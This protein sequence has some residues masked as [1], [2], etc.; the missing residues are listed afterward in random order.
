MLG[1][2][3][4]A[5]ADILA[6]WHKFNDGYGL[7][8]TSA[9]TKLADVYLS[10][11]TATIYGGGGSRDTWGSTDGTFGAS[12]AVG[13]SATDGAM[14]HRTDKLDI[15]MT[16]VNNTGSN[17]VLD[18]LVFD[19]ASVSTNA[20]KDLALYYDSGNL[21]V[22]AGTLVNSTTGTNANGLTFVSDYQDFDWSLTGL[23]DRTLAT[24]ET[25]VF[26]FTVSN[27]SNSTQALALDNIAILGTGTPGGPLTTAMTA[28][29]NHITGTSTLTNTQINSQASVIATY[30]DQIGDTDAYITQALDLVSTY[31]TIKGAL[32]LNSTTSATAGFSR[33]DTS[34][35]DKALAVAMLG[36]Y[37][38]LIDDA[39][40]SSNLA[41]RRSLLEG[42]AFASASYFPGAVT[43]PANPNAVYSVQIN[44]SQP[45]AWG[46]E[47]DFQTQPAR[48]PTGAYLAPGS[49]AT[50]TVPPA[51]VNKGFQVRVGAHVADLKNKGSVKRF[52]RTTL[53][54]NITSTDTLVANPLGGGIYIEVPYLAAEGLVTVDIKNTV[55]SPFYSNTVARQTTL[56]Q[57]QT[58]ERNHPGPWA[59]FESDKFMMNVPRGWI[60]NYADPV[61]TMANW[62]LA[63]DAVSDL[64]GLPRVRPKTV[65]YCQIDVLI[66]A[67]AFSPGY[68]QSNDTYS[69]R[70]AV[71]GNQNH[72]LLNGPKFC[73]H[74]LFHELGHAAA[75]TKFNGELE[76]VV[77]LLYVPVHNRMFGVSLDEAFG[78]SLNTNAGAAMTR[79]H[80]ALNWV[81]TEKFRNGQ[82][83]AATEMNYQHRGYGKYVEIAGLFGWEALGNFW[84]SVAVDYE[85]GITYSKNS[86]PPDSRIL[87][88]S[89]AAGVDLT[90]L[91]H[92]WGVHPNNASSLKA[93]IQAAQL[94]KSAK[95]YDRLVYY[96]TQVPMS[97]SEFA[98]HDSAIHNLI[99]VNERDWYTSMR[100]GWTQALGLASVAKIQEIID[101]Y[102]P[103]GRPADGLVERI[104]YSES[105]ENGM[106]QWV[107]VLTDDY[108]WTRY[109][110]YTPTADSGPSAASDGTFYLYAEGH[111]TGSNKTTSIECSF[112]LTQVDTATLTFDYHMFGPYIDY[113]SLDVFNGTTWVT[114]VWKKSG[115]QQATS[116][117]PWLTASVSLAPYARNTIK[118]RFNAKNSQWNA[119][120]SAI[121][122]IRITIPPQQLPYAESFETG[123]GS[124]TQS[125]ADDFD[126]TRHSGYTETAN[127]GPSGAS[128]GTY[129]IYLEGHD[130]GVQYKSALME[131][132]FDFSGMST[133]SMTFDYHIYGQYIDYLAL[134]VFAGSTWTLDV[135]KRTN[136]QQAS[137]EDPW[138][139]ASVNL[140]PYAGNSNVTL[141]FRSKNKQWHAADT[142]L[143]NLRVFGTPVS[144]YAT[145]SAGH[146]LAGGFDADDDR[147]GIANGM[148]FV[149][150]G[151]PMVPNTSI[152]P[153]A[154]TDATHL[155]FSYTR[156][157]D[158]KTSTAQTVQW[159]TDLATWT[160][161]T[162]DPGGPDSVTINIPLTHEVN[163]KLYARLKV[164]K[165]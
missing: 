143:D 157:A 14:G 63:M 85:N 2:A 13:T 18:S 33:T 113:L 110:G 137:S 133:V 6:G 94:P 118:L 163:G 66:D 156:T 57:W 151:N 36:V 56:A 20:P 119:S 19:L 29:K 149:L 76:S 102:F 72:D 148:E 103:N 141:R 16:L 78:R 15:F 158:S 116:E 71:N 100:T 145:W 77:N 35:V 109:S 81:V 122:N 44:A 67:S 120:D 8:Q 4:P 32:F 144:P 38:A 11:L 147:D 39:F 9:S 23:A 65:L 117:D 45:K 59:D 90:P 69:P 80:A 152:L 25:A 138:L 30:K 105:F 126:W 114:D 50:V 75:I 154:V 48:R 95:I 83:M 64:Q 7:Y 150:N 82:P 1:A 27:A 86:D 62:D 58:T 40:N 52:D 135:W 70:T 128:D 160:D 106:G 107:Q 61:T 112:D 3:L 17:V 87:R 142:A 101:L 73:D 46:Y 26:R 49:V 91:I 104:P 60:Y 124:W 93:S 55:R 146:S 123:L 155:K 12:T 165:P 47:V 5:H 153:T 98:A 161:I 68:P 34:S 24:G 140:T 164:A 162:V 136:Q 125:T 132:A 51:L 127:T 97:A 42:A 31:E 108:D 96:Q 21:G 10:G 129:Y 134:D 37:Q 53:V 22:P 41:I 139:N 159:S 54:Y 88:M 131:R 84:N 89:K 115:A 111:D 92:F 99:S 130:N 43:P 79:R 121:D 28:L 74:V